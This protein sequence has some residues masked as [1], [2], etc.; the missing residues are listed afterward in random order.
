MRIRCHGVQARPNPLS[1]KTFDYYIR[2]HTCDNCYSFLLGL[3][4]WDPWD[5][6]AR[7]VIR[8]VCHPESKTQFS[9]GPL[10]EAEEK[11]D[12]TLPATKRH[13]APQGFTT[14]ATNIGK[15]A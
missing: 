13:T 1:T 11:K 4:S 8:W 2:S 7:Q 6:T 9:I 5:Y 12:L 15:E 14:S 3:D 10:S